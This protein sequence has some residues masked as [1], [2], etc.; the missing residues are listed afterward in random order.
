MRFHLAVLWLFPFVIYTQSHEQATGYLPVICV[1]FQC[2]KA[3]KSSS[4]VWELLH[5]LFI[6]SVF[7][8]VEASCSPEFE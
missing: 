2:V 1:V 8:S 6:L 5:H 3:T 7:L 4:S